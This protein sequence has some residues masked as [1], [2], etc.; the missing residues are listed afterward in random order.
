VE[1]IAEVVLPDNPVAST[2]TSAVTKRMEGLSTSFRS[3]PAVIFRLS[4]STTSRSRRSA[5]LVPL[6]RCA[7]PTAMTRNGEKG[8]A[9]G[10]A[11][12]ARADGSSL[13]VPSAATPVPGSARPRERIRT[14]TTHLPH[15]RRGTRRMNTFLRRSLLRTTPEGVTS[16]GLR[17]V[18]LEGA[19]PRSAERVRLLGVDPLECGD[20][21]GTELRPGVRPQL[22]DGRIDGNALRYGRSLVIA[23]SSRR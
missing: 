13:P 3:S 16:Y 21:R 17:D 1:S 14:G 15:R 2:G 6:T 5:K 18:F 20:H 7:S 12:S 9:I 11:S 23:S 22:R 10:L 19:K 4:A 8:V